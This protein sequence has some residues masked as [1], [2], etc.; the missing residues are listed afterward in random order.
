MASHSCVVSGS[1]TTPQGLSLAIS[2]WLALIVLIVLLVL[3]AF[4][5]RSA[6]K[7]HRSARRAAEP[8]APGGT[9]GRPRDAAP[10][11]AGDAAAQAVAAQKATPFWYLVLGDDIAC[12]R[13]RS[14]CLWTVALAYALLVIAFHEAVYPPGN[15]DPRYLLLLGFPA[16]AAVSAKAITTGQIDNGTLRRPPRHTRKR[17]WSLRSVTSSRMI[18]V[19]LTSA[20]LSTSCST[21]WR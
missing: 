6:Q 11:A 4:A 1:A 20:T 15:L 5:A 3:L 18:K 9:A 13:R 17:A 10:A 7:P 16:G 19:I 8:P 21:S 14:S 2:Y 12:Q